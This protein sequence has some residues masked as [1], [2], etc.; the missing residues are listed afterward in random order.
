MASSLI[1]VLIII[2]CAVFQ[3][4]KG[5]VV[6]AFA[7]IIVA[8]I[9]GMVAFGF[10]EALANVFISR[11]DDSRFISLVPWAHL[12]DSPRADHFGISSHRFPNGA[13]TRRISL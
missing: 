1:V 5:T 10:F 3:Y 8:I 12:W 7:T 4:F 13:I 9:A 6:R 2:G 11:G